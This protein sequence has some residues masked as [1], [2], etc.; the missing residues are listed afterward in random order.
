VE[1]IPGA[2]HVFNTPN[3]ATL[4]AAPSGQLAA[5]IRPIIGFLDRKLA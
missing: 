5:V 3:P 1:I 2:D 4:D